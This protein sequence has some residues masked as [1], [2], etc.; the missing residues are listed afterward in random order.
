MIV[1]SSNLMVINHQLK[2]VD[3]QFLI[4]SHQ[5]YF[6]KGEVQRLLSES[7]IEPSRSLWRA[8]VVVT[9]DDNHKKRLV[10]D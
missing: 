9:K 7:I 6:V 10:I 5:I 8:Q 1:L 3:Y 2:Y 4:L